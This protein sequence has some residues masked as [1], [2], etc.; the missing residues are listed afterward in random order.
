M[1]RCSLDEGGKSWERSDQDSFLNA[2]STHLES[3]LRVLLLCH[4]SSDCDIR[5]PGI[6]DGK[7]QYGRGVETPSSL[8]TSRYFH[9]PTQDHGKDSL[10]R[11]LNL[12]QAKTTAFSGTPESYDVNHNQTELH[13]WNFFASTSSYLYYSLRKFVFDIISFQRAQN[14]YLQSHKWLRRITP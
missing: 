4:S 1:V 11:S 3:L 2:C 10:E 5:C 14:S 8:S 6:D 9:R 12:Q 7:S 13:P